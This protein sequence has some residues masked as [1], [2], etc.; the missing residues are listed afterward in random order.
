MRCQFNRTACRRPMVVSRRPSGNC[1]SC[2]RVTVRKAQLRAVAQDTNWLLSA[3]SNSCRISSAFFAC[4]KNLQ[5]VSSRS[6]R[7]TFSSARKWSPG[8]SGGEM[9]KK[10]QVYL[11]AIQ[12]VEI[13]PLGTDAHGADQPVHAGMLGMRNGHAATDAGAAE[14]LALQN[15]FDDAFVFGWQ[16][17]Y[18]RRAKPEPSRESRTLCHRP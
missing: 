12:A 11:L 16:R 17:S 10:E 9:S 8:R 1:P 18:P 5:N 15:G 6:C 14:F 13:D 4:F 2:D 3:S 7:E